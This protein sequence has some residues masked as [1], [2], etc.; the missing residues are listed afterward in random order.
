MPDGRGP[1]VLL[2]GVGVNADTKRVQKTCTRKDNNMGDAGHGV[3][4]RIEPL[5]QAIFRGL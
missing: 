5:T 1:L 3:K 4:T 2:V